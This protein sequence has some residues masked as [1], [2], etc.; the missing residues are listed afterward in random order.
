MCSSAFTKPITYIITIETR[1]SAI[2]SKI[3]MSFS[4][5]TGHG[6][7]HLAMR[8]QVSCRKDI[9]YVPSFAQVLIMKWRQRSA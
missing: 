1:H 8:E 9:Y 3:C 4:P 5:E 2:R 7:L 6:G